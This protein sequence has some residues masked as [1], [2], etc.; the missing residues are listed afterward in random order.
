M[1]DLAHLTRREKRFLALQTLYAARALARRTDDL[2]AHVAAIFDGALDSMEIT[3][4]VH[5]DEPAAE[6][7]E[8]ALDAQRPPT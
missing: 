6:I 3:D 4:I 1:N 5:N 7:I 2:V 8:A